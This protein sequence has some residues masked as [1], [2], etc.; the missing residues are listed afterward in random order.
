MTDQPRQ[1]RGPLHASVQE[2]S[3]GLYSAR[4]SGEINPDSAGAE[5][6]PDA[7]VSS[8]P[9]GVRTWVEQMAHGMGYDGV[10]W[11]DPV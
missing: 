8:S 1:T 4:Y 3:S 2:V 7:H 9:E 5:A 6:I 11:E 10:I